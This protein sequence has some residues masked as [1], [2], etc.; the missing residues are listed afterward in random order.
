MPNHR[1]NPRI[2]GEIKENPSCLH[3]KNNG[4]FIRNVLPGKNNFVS[5]SSAAAPKICCS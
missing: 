1:R 5:S 3:L 2:D 4:K